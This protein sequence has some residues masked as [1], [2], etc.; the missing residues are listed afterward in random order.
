MVKNT[1]RARIF[2]TTKPCGIPR[3]DRNSIF[4]DARW[5]GLNC[6]GVLRLSPVRVRELL[7]VAILTILGAV[8]VA[9]TT[10]DADGVAML[11]PAK[12][13]GT[14]YRLGTNNPMADPEHLRLKPTTVTQMTENGV[15]FWRSAGARVTYASGAPDGTTHR[16]MI[17]ASGGTQTYN[18]Q[19]GAI[20]KGYCGNVNDLNAFEATVY[21][22]LNDL[23]GTHESVSWSIRGGTHNGPN[24]SSIGL[25]L[26]N[27]PRGGTRAAY[28][29]L[30]WPTY[31][32]A[33]STP[34]FNYT[35]VSGDWVGIKIVSYLTSST[36]VRNL[37]YLDT[38]PYDRSGGKNNTWRLYLDW[39][40][41]QGVAM[42]PYTQAAL[43]AGWMN[44]F[45]V[46]G[47][48]LVDFSILS[49]REIQ[50]PPFV[51]SNLTATTISQ[52][53]I[54][55]SWTDQATG[56]LG[57]KIER[58]N[59]N[60]S[61]SYE[62]IGMVGANFTSFNDTAVG[63][64]TSY[65]Y[66]VRAYNASADSDYSNVATQATSEITSGRMGHWKFD[67][68]SGITAADNSG[69]ANTGTILGATWMAAGKIGFG[70]NFD[71][72]DAVNA[73]SGATLNNL[74][75]M[76]I[77]AWIKPNTLGGGASGRIVQKGAG[78]GPGFRFMLRSNNA[79]AFAVDYTTTDL[80]RA[81]ANSVLTLGVWTHVLV[82]WTGSA[83]ATNVKIYLNGVETAYGA[84][85]TGAGTRANDAASSLYIGN[86]GDG[87]GA[88]DGLMDDVR[89]YNRV[90]SANEITAV[91]RAGVR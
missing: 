82:T 69:N 73:G 56:E 78:A 81:T 20:T 79:L 42:G 39:T 66:R 63:A 16:L 18:W 12:P 26:K 22:R 62:Q 15:T 54:R 35:K 50:P 27:G 88:F 3:K 19:T 65:R 4:A 67:E 53:Q 31:G 60:A 33:D 29:E 68:G 1:P 43:W 52:S 2:S 8:S 37:M 71:G 51:P 46:D 32:Y 13:G 57:F 25:F 10:Y 6:R 40:D 34:F 64:G 84:T 55:L 87:T 48:R 49:A 24:S 91:Y 76:T 89:V 28:K 45:R 14:S 11:F 61:G 9:A 58:Q 83:T 59:S 77:S 41:T 44:M 75:A 23:T 17:F 85:Q 72:V 86:E 7:A 74:R 80:S 90:L 5:G 30:T 38:A 21:C 70:L 36:T 47:W